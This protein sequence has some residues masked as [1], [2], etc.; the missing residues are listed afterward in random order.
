VHKTSRASDDIAEHVA[1][2]W[3]DG[4]CPIFGPSVVKPGVTGFQLCPTSTIRQSSEV[5]M[6]ANNAVEHSRGEIEKRLWNAADE[7]R[8]NSRL[9]APGSFPDEVT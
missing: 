4:V 3:A 2:A 5:R 6:P 8:A 1:T 9:K 7:L